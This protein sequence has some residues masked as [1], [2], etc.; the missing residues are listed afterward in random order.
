LKKSFEVVHIVLNENFFFRHLNPA[1]TEY[2]YDIRTQLRYGWI[3]LAVLEDPGTR[4]S[5]SVIEFTA[6]ETKGNLGSSR[7]LA[8][9]FQISRQFDILCMVGSIS[10]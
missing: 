1:T 8:P 9:Q 6:V 4:I 5:L 2:N 10:M 3:I 7:A